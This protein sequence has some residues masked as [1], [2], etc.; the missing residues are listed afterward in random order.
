[1]YNSDNG[2]ISFG[3]R[4]LKITK[5]TT[6]DDIE[7]FLSQTVEETID[8]NYDI[9]HSYR[10]PKSRVKDLL[11]CKTA[12]EAAKIVLEYPCVNVSSEQ[13]DYYLDTSED[14]LVDLKN[15]LKEDKE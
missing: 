8:I 6:P 15:Y 9:D 10:V 4:E 2:T 5:G 14:S 1:M 3:S 12:K 7:E 13:A 11:E